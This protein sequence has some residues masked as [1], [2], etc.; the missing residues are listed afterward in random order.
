MDGRM[1]GVLG[2]LYREVRKVLQQTRLR[3]SG[4]KI[5]ELLRIGSKWDG[6]S[7]VELPA[8]RS[9]PRPR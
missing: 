7:D 9:T 8:I 2:E 6:N 1:F 5:D 4:D 3:G